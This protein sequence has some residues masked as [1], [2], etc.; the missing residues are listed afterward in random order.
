MTLDEITKREGELQ[1][2]LYERQAEDSRFGI[3][4]NRFH[5]AKTYQ[6][7]DSSPSYGATINHGPSLRQLEVREDIRQIKEALADL[8]QLRT[9]ARAEEE[10]KALAALKPTIEAEYCKIAT[11]L[12]QLYPS[13]KKL[14]E[15]EEG[16]ATR[17]FS[18]ATVLPIDFDGVRGVNI[19]DVLKQFAERGLCKAPK[20]I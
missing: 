14:E 16:L 11:T 1:D 8:V 17:G 10:K 5:S 7:M 6:P 12:S 9:A 3:S 20:G 13:L 18:S 15:I 19:A 2:R 4:T